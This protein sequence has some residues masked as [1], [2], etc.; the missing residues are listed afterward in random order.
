LSA[1]LL[2]GQACARAM[3]AELAARARRIAAAGVRPGLA[4]VRVGADAA[5]E[6]HVPAETRACAEAGVRY[7]A[8]AFDAAAE[9]STLLVRIGELNADPAVHGILVQ[10]P[11]PPQLDAARVRRAVAPHKDVDGDHACAAHAVVA[12]LQAGR[13]RL[14]GREAVIVARDALLGGAMGRV[15]RARRATVTVCSL[16][17]PA[18]AEHTRRADILV[19][20]A[21]RRGLVRGDMV[22]PG[23][24]VI[25]AGAHRLADGR[26]VGDVDFHEV[27]ERAGHISPV[28]GG[29]G[30]MTLTMLLANTVRAAEGRARV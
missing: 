23:A 4:V 27:R 18:L 15:L 29:L 12:L 21:G 3:R 1:A 26:L 9:E 5:T 6:V 28:P 16:R 24:A 10:L 22:K 7:A 17:A 19:V 14:A 2:D 8:H 11:L 13:V 20:A 30:P 25:D